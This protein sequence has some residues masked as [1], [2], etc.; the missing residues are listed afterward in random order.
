M[1]PW[2]RAHTALVEDLSSVSIWIW[3]HWWSIEN[4]VN[5]LFIDKKTKSRGLSLARSKL[6]FPM[7][8]Y[9]V[10]VLMTVFHVRALSSEPHMQLSYHQ[11]LI[12]T[13]DIGIPFPTSN[14]PNPDTGL[15][16]RHLTYSRA[17]VSG[18]RESWSLS[19]FLRAFFSQPWA[20]TDALVNRLKISY[21]CPI[22]KPLNLFIPC[23]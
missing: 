15:Q 14:F 6:L 17:P 13:H 23:I 7:M 10:N 21:N 1:V 2:L 4:Y 8:I 22:N 19:F 5:H 11:L 18:S 9:W 16:S 12:V 20:S 3:I